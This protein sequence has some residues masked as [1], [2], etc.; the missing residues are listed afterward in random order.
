M[1]IRRITLNRFGRLHGTYDFQPDR[2]NIICEHNEFGKSTLVDAILFGLYNMPRAKAT[3]GLRAR[4]KYR[5]WSDS[6]TQQF[7][8]ELLVEDLDGQDYRIEC[9]FAANN[10]YRVINLATGEQFSGVS[11]FGRHFL[12]MPL[13]SFTECFLLRQGDGDENGRDEL[14]ELIQSASAGEQTSHI[15]AVQHALEQLRDSRSRF[16][17]FVTSETEVPLSQELRARIE[18]CEARIRELEDAHDKATWDA[19][20]LTALQEAEQQLHADEAELELE[21][22]ATELAEIE[23]QIRG[24]N[25]SHPDEG[26]IPAAEGGAYSKDAAR[27][28][29]QMLSELEKARAELSEARRRLDE[30]IIDRLRR[31]RELE[32]VNGVVSELPENEMERLRSRSAI[33]RERK[34][35]VDRQRGQTDAMREGLGSHNIPQPDFQELEELLDRLPPGDNRILLQY[36]SRQSEIEG[37]LGQA[38]TQSAEA[39]AQVSYARSRR[40][41]LRNE[42]NL[43]FMGAVFLG[44]T[45]C[46]FLLMN[47]VWKPALWV[48]L[49]MIAL[50]AAAAAAGTRA[51]KRTHLHDTMELQPALEME[52]R[53][54]GETRRL[55]EQIENLRQEFKITTQRLHLTWDDVQLMKKMSKW[56]GVILPYQ[57]ARQ[58][59]TLAEKGCAEVREDI[60]RFLRRTGFPLPRNGVTD[61]DIETAIQ[62]AE[63]GMSFDQMCEQLNAEGARL[64]ERIEQLEATAA[65]FEQKLE[66]IVGDE[67]GTDVSQRVQS[68]IQKCDHAGVVQ[69]AVADAKP[70]VAIEQLTERADILRTLLSDAR[71][72][73]R[74][75]V[76]SLEETRARLD[77]IRKQQQDIAAE[78][79]IL[80]GKCERAFDACREELSGLRAEREFL[81]E[82]AARVGQTEAAL[83]IAREQIEAAA[84]EIFV[85]WAAALSKR[86]NEIITAV[87]P[88]YRDVEISEDLDL[89]VFSIEHNRRV[90]YREIGHLSKG[91]RDQLALALRVAI[92]EYLSSHIGPLPI[93]LD[94]PFAHWDDERFMSGI[95]FLASLVERHQVI[96]LSCHKWRYEQLARENPALYRELAFCQIA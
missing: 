93:V 40:K 64:M 90:R 4:D 18:A 35:E 19:Q 29:E 82:K 38:Q 45:G 92:A 62:Q 81:L 58:H 84:R 20:R 24:G 21:T 59:L 79:Q 36:E 22:A 95:Q 16:P 39:S 25:G 42:S 77:E 14:I 13:A 70:P 94:E 87:N 71:G 49:T 88:G 47:A 54:S 37:Q 67:S 46:L 17:E 3:G 32:S 63:A 56:S 73:S 48:G 1:Q 33:Y 15:G 23:E 85:A 30:D 6:D 57:T 31:L 26:C 78:S 80:S 52:A 55:T 50:A 83:A 61:A 43:F 96:L 60:A 76:M 75:P 74:T 53:H 2:C 12:H 8:L 10:G 11:S 44:A 86:V 7:G 68:F 34:A 27:D 91:A 65:R 89:S 72:L 28:V 66:E 51:L 41:K 5:P 9:D 69:A